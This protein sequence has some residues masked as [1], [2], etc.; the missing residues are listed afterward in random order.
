M[1]GRRI[2]SIGQCGADHSRFT[3]T[4]REHFNAEVVSAD[5]AAEASQWL[6]DGPF[7]LIL[8][9]RVL[10]SNGSSGVEI[11]KHLK[12]K[13]VAQ[14]IPAMLVSNYDDAQE[15]AVKY[16][17]LKGFGKSALGQPAM[18]SRV[19]KVLGDK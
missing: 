13:P 2:L 17:A 12:A 15:E 4:F 6:H 18:I 11:I 19:R 14:P 5:D 3:Q 7:D 8:V 10:D 1:T 9:N 16:G